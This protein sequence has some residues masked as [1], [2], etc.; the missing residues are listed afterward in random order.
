M[1]ALIIVLSVLSLWGI[2]LTILGLRNIEL[3]MATFEERQAR[4]KIDGG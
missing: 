4:K 1:V 2:Y 3:I